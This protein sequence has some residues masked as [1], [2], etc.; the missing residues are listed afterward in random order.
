M[1]PTTEQSDGLSLRAYLRVVVR[2]KW[3]ILALTI[4]FAAAA[5]AYSHTRTPLYQAAA[6]LMYEPQVNVVDLTTGTSA[7]ST[8]LT[9][10]IESVATLLG[11]T[12]V[13]QAARQQLGAV[14]SW[15]TVAAKTQLAADNSGNYSSIVLVEGVS[16]N[17][18]V[19]AR[20]ANAYAQAF[21]NW[22]K[23]SEQQRLQQ[24]ANV[25]Q[26]TLDTYTSSAA[27]TSSEY[28]MFQ[29]EYRDLQILIQTATGDFSVI[30]QA[31]PPSAPFSPRTTRTAAVG[32]AGGL[33]LGLLL[34][35]LLEQFDTRLRSEEQ[36]LDLLNYPVLGRI[37]RAVKKDMANGSEVATLSNSSGHVAEAFRMLRSNLDFVN[38]DGGVRTVLV[39]SSAQREGKSVASCNLA[40]SLALAGKRVALIDG[41]LRNPHVH[42]YL[43]LT[44]AVGLSSVLARGTQLEDALVHMSLSSTVQSGKV[45]Q[46]S[47]SQARGASVAKVSPIETAGDWEERLW[48]SAAGDDEMP[49][50]VLTSGPTPPNAGELAAS[51]RMKMIIDELAAH[52]DI[53]LIDAPAMLIVGDT[54]ALASRVDG[55]LY[56]VDPDIARRPMLD[57]AAEQLEQLPCR[58]L[59]LVLMMDGDHG[60]YYTYHSH[61]FEEDT[62]FGRR[63]SK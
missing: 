13:G 45:A 41:D 14:N 29:Q 36:I 44:N 56:V 42:T 9:A 46:P 28:M 38:V 57:R 60:H 27:R 40:V 18:S 62:K 48:S 10:D 31:T 25:V 21:V 23:Q 34:A 16:P 37:P 5:F 4:V 15:Y 54:V 22:R 58:K 26:A 43:G 59:G 61:H 6:Q 51:G 33:L 50:A 52:S 19:A 12:A 32:V 7:S 8:Q 1:T 53:V 49:L 30:I 39:T 63:R 20:A 35:F 2:W 3:L 24:A 11:T 47:R 55:V 17:A